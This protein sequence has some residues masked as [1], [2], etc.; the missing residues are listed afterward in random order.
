MAGSTLLVIS[1]HA[2]AFP[3]SWSLACVQDPPRLLRPNTTMHISAAGF[4]TTLPSE[5][6]RPA[7]RIHWS[8]CGC[9]AVTGAEIDANI[10]QH[11]DLTVG[12]SQGLVCVLASLPSPEFEGNSPPLVQTLPL[13]FEVAEV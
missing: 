2:A 11:G 3:N 10:S 1:A 6:H 4:N 8:K 5:E 7:S 12:T 13:L 9:N